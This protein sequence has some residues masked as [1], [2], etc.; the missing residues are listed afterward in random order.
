MDKL[1]VR[2]KMKCI[3]V[4]GLKVIA[5]N[6]KRFMKYMQGGYK[7]AKKDK[8]TPKGAVCL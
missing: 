4:C 7:K 1:R 8:L 3:V 6:V 5:Q 2:G